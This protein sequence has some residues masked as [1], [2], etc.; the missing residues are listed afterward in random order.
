MENDI[1]KLRSHYEGELLDEKSVYPDPIEQFKFWFNE[2]LNSNVDEPNAMILATASKSG[3]PSARAVLLKDFD[4]KGF[5]FYTNYNSKKGKDLDENPNASILFFWPQLHRQ[6]RIDG[7][8]S[9]IDPVVSQAYFKERPRGSQI[10]AWVSAQSCELDNKFTLENNYKLFDIECNGKE[11]P[12]PS[13]WGGYCLK[14][15]SYEFWQGQPNRLHD[16]I[17]F[18]LKPEDDKWLIKRLAP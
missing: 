16:R 12:Y 15:F 1:S 7:T 17:Q 14:P 13:F 10:S 18:S 5:T 6:I 8:V 4:Q 9:Q 2:A 3:I 11:V